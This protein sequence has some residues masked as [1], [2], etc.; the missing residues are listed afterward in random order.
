MVGGSPRRT[1]CSLGNG[2]RPCSQAGWHPVCP[3]S[4]LFFSPLSQAVPASFTCAVMPSIMAT[5]KTSV[6]CTTNRSCKDSPAQPSSREAGACSPEALLRPPAHRQPV[7]D[8]QG[9]LCLETT[10][11]RRYG[12]QEQVSER[13]RPRKNV[14][15]T[16]P[17]K[18]H[19]LERAAICQLAPMAFKTLHNLLL[20]SSS[21]S[22]PQNPTLP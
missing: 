17:G 13:L 15:P 19:H 2:P 10:C 11:A 4:L 8:A 14:Q 18:A 1:A 9:A 20:S 6:T 7:Q 22:A 12:D 3:G 5:A 16:K 21:P